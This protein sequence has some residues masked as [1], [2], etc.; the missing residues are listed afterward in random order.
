[1]SKDKD[2]PLSPAEYEQFLGG[3]TEHLK[4]SKSKENP[5][6]VLSG[7]L[8]KLSDVLKSRDRAFQHLKN[9]EA[10]AVK[11]LEYSKGNKGSGCKK[12]IRKLSLLNFHPMNDVTKIWKEAQDGMIALDPTRYE[13]GEE[14]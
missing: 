6:L 1:M 11:E 12:N 10:L 4:K 5:N 7:G 8:S 9:I 14:E 3:F 13:G 2:K